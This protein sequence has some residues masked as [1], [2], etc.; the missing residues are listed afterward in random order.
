MLTQTLR[1]SGFAELLH[2][3]ICGMLWPVADKESGFKAVAALQ[4][5]FREVT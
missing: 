5:R 1:F 2:F 3:G 4:G